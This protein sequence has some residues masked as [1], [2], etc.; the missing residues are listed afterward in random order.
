MAGAAKRTLGDRTKALSFEAREVVVKPS[1][2]VSLET[3][4]FSARICPILDKPRLKNLLIRPAHLP[5]LTV[6]VSLKLDFV[7]TGPS[8]LSK[9]RCAWGG[10]IEIPADHSKIFRKVCEPGAQF[11]HPRQSLPG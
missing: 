6:D 5:G 1:I 10:H 9:Q 4:P 3:G 2:T 8:S 11:L 7:V